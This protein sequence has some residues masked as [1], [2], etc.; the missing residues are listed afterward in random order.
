MAWAMLPGLMNLTRMSASGGMEIGDG[1]GG[2]WS[3]GWRRDP[4]ERRGDAAHQVYPPYRT[5]RAVALVVGEL[6]A[7]LQ[8]PASRG[9]A[10]LGGRGPAERAEGIGQMREGGTGY[11]SPQQF[12]KLAVEE[13]ICDAQ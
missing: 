12:P 2:S 9:A 7:S 3:G 4:S 13:S 5:A 1:A 10:C 6:L 11:R 8:G